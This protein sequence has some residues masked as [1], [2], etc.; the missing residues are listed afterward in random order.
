[1]KSKVYPQ[2]SAM[3]YN[4]I[5]NTCTGR[6]TATRRCFIR[7]RKRSGF[8][9]F[10]LL[11][12]MVIIGLLAAISGPSLL[13]LSNSTGRKGAVNVLM[14]AFE[15]ARVA[16]LTSGKNS[17]V[18]FATDM[19]FDSDSDYLYRAFIIFRESTDEEQADGAGPFVALTKWEE[20]PKNIYFKQ[21][22]KSLVGTQTTAP[23]QIDIQGSL[24]QI[25]AGR[26]IPVIEFNSFGA[27]QNPT[28]TPANPRIAIFITENRYNPSDEQLAN[29][30]NLLDSI[31]FSRYTGRAQFEV[32][33]VN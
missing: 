30:G 25:K 15:Q 16:A 10:E 17:Y 28:P 21:D 20:L 2:A 23:Y 4:D 27:I 13:H 8:S 9:L 1:M 22:P 7:H 12:V 24:P 6:M 31:S 3:W 33:T 11:A 14:N 5:V 29:Q 19:G 26:S 18:G 32:S